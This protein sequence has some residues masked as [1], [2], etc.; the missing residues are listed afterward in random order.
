MGYEWNMLLWLAIFIVGMEIW[1]MWMA[2]SVYRASGWSERDTKSHLQTNKPEFI[3]LYVH[4][5]N[6]D[7]YFMD[8]SA[9]ILNS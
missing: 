7:H 8:D 4:N 3:L 6:L 5:N 1:A 9:V 2:G